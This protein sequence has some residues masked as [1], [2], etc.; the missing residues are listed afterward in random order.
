MALDLNGIHDRFENYV[1]QESLNPAAKFTELRSRLKN[2]EDSRKQRNAEDD[3]QHQ[4][5]MPWKEKFQ[6]SKSESFSIVNTKKAGVA[7]SWLVTVLAKRVILLE[8]AFWEKA[9]CGKC[10]GKSHLD[11]ACRS[12]NSEKI[13]VQRRD[14]QCLHSVYMGSSTNV[15]SKKKVLSPI[16]F[17]QEGFFSKPL[18]KW[19]QK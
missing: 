14:A 17:L 9:E 3:Q 5:A 11:V 8:I 19:I 1:V 10:G 15:V 12:K 16:T 18:E 13:S 4:L 7:R 2:F 6:S